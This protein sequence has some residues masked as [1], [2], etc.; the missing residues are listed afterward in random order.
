M[1]PTERGYVR[2]LLILCVLAGAVLGLWPSLDLAVSGFFYAP[3]RGFLLSGSTASELFRARVWDLSILM[4]LVTLLGMVL[5][6]FKRRLWKVSS[7]LWIYLFTL[8]LLG[9]LI[10]VN[11]ILKA[12]WGRA[13][14]ADIVEF[15]GAHQFTPFWQPADQCLKNCSFVSG[16]VSAVFALSLAL[17]MV[18]STATRSLRGPWRHICRVLAFALPPLVMLQRLAAGRHFLSDVV[19]AGLFVL[20]LACALK[21]LLAIGRHRED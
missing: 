14:P 11:G 3:D 18:T 9:P 7:G 15:G 1:W 8:Y 12:H 13:R 5:A 4:F 21:P 16:E 6:V 19:F 20:L 2:T 17:L 10:L